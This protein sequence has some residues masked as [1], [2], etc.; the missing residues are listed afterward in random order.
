MSARRAAPPL[1][2]RPALAS[3]LR[4]L[5]AANR[6]PHTLHSYETSVLQYLDFLARRGLAPV[7]GPETRAWVEE[8]IAEVLTLRKASTA[9]T[10]YNGLK[11]FFAWLVQEGELEHS[12]MEGTTRPRGK[13]PEPE[14]LSPED[15]RRLLATC[16]RRTF[17]GRRDAA[18]IRFLWDTGVRVGGLV[19]MTVEATDLDDRGRDARVPRRIT[20]APRSCRQDRLSLRVGRR[21]ASAAA[22]GD[23]IGGDITAAG[24]SWS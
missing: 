16:D 24:T 6:S 8:F 14:P 11:A 12:P 20:S 5:R 23:G 18:I 7:V 19:S 17:V 2:L 13:I 22:G 9:E 10:R 15:A 3:W 4:S 1:P 21:E